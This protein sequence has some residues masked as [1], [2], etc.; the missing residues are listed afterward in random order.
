MRSVIASIIAFT[1]RIVAGIIL[2]VVVS[3]IY[4]RLQDWATKNIYG[5]IVVWGRVYRV[6]NPPGV[7][8]LSGNKKVN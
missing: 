5:H 4:A 3:S 7:V 6:S 2:T 1:V 8:A